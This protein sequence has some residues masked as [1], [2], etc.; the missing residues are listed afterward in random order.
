ML[1]LAQRLFIIIPNQSNPFPWIHDFLWSV[2][3]TF[4]ILS[5][6]WTSHSKG[7]RSRKILQKETLLR[8]RLW[9]RCSHWWAV[10]PPRTP[11]EV[12]R[13]PHVS[14]ILPVWTKGPQSDAK[15]FYS[16]SG[17]FLF[18]G[19]GDLSHRKLDYNTGQK[20][21]YYFNFFFNYSLLNNTF[22]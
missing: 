15:I 8:T 10:T 2:I 16:L 4:Q 11:V 9:S 22:F 13:S 5:H 18:H 17:E 3:A 1:F 6:H 12:S 7:D 14:S 21:R 20:Q 19:M